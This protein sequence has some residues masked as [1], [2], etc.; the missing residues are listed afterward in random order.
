MIKFISKLFKKNKKY[1]VLLLPVILSILLILI[2]L[3][4]KFDVSVLLEYEL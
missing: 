3:I 1:I 4:F 2:F